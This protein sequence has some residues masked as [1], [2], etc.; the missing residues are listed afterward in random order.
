MSPLRTHDS[1]TPEP[2]EPAPSIL[3][4]LF[5]EMNELEDEFFLA[6]PEAK[7]ELTEFDDYPEIEVSSEF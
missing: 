4:K 1:T 6:H 5:A 3:D 7:G 2:L